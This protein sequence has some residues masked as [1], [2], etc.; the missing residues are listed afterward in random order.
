MRTPLIAG[1]VLALMTAGAVTLGTTTAQGMGASEKTP[2][3]FALGGS[4]FGSRGEGGDVPAG[5]DTTAYQVIGCNNRAGL[6]RENHLEDTTVPGLGT[7]HN[8]TTTVWTTTSGGTVAS[9]SRNSIEQ[10]TIGDPSAGALELHAVRSDSRAFHDG[11]GYHST[12][13]THVGSLTFTPP[14]GEPQVLDLP[15]PDQ[16]VTVPGLAT[17]AIG[18]AR[19]LHDGDGAKASANAVD[20]T[21]L[22]TGSRFRIA[23]S[24]AQIGEGVRS[25]LFRGYSSSSRNRGLD[26]N[27]TTGKTSYLL[28]PCQGTGGDLRRKSI[29]HSTPRSDIEIRNAASRESGTQNASTASGFEQGSISR[30]AIGGDL[31]VKAIVGRV[32]V[33]RVGDKVIRSIDGTS[34]GTIIANGEPQTFPDTDVLEIPGVARL[35]RNIVKKTP[36]GM[37]V[38]SLRITLLDGTGAVLNLGLARLEI[39]DSGN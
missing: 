24:A 35:E 11:S 37:S 9:N 7:M 13:V 32:N 31:L 30:I 18:D 8:I 29:A 20:I 39:L 6:N 1:S 27:V 36:N 12:T 14:G 25:G 21:V 26:D 4:G 3:Q 23:H 38:I 34:I 5:T 19:E 28:M 17:I 10:L 22:A 16:P 33:K 2:T 15:T